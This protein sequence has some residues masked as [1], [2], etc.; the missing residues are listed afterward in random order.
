VPCPTGI[1][2][3]DDLRP[4]CIIS[5]LSFLILSSGPI[6]ATAQI[7]EK[8]VDLTW[9]DLR[10]ILRTPEWLRLVEENPHAFDNEIARLFIAVAKD[11]E[12]FVRQITEWVFNAS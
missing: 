4:P 9:N 10:L 1:S 7:A 6:T 2:L 3:P 12:D 5:G 8:I 11:N